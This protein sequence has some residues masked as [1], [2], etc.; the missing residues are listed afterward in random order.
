M[1]MKLNRDPGFVAEVAHRLPVLW[2]VRHTRCRLS[3][4][5]A[6]V[7]PPAEAPLEPA[8]R[9][10]L[11]GLRLARRGFISRHNASA[12]AASS[13]HCR[14]RSIDSRVRQLKQCSTNQ[15]G[16]AYHPPWGLKTPSRVTLD[17]RKPVLE[18]MMTGCLAAPSFV[19]K[20]YYSSRVPGLRLFSIMDR[21]RRVSK[22]GVRCSIGSSY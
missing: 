11:G 13:A 21:Y 19:G 8:P 1:L 15:H 10:R 12:S 4:A 9:Q 6:H 7:C 22:A 18:G 20:P 16:V 2:A 3:Q 14:E 17:K 5:R